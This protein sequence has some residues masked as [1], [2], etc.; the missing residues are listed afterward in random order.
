MSGVVTVFGSGRSEPGSPLYHEA[1]RL[2]ELLGAAGFG[3]ATGGYGGVMEAVLRGA[4]PYGVRRIGVVTPELQHRQVNPYVGEL[5]SEPTYLRRL[6]RLLQL[7]H[8]YVLL[9][10]ETGTLLEFCAVLALRERSLLPSRP[11]LCLGEFWRRVLKGVVEALPE[12]DRVRQYVSLCGSPE[13]V[14]EQLH[15][16]LPGR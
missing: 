7:G 11:L 15:R 1:V 9:A 13:E 8:A 5:L 14:L 16:L 12:P 2:G 4:A 6:E 3:I 10:G